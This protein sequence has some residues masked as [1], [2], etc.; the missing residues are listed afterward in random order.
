[1]KELTKKER[2]A[3]DLEAEKSLLEDIVFNVLDK[4]TWDDKKKIDTLLLYDATLNLNLDITNKT[5]DKKRVLRK[6][7]II[8]RAI[9]QIDKALGD[10]F[11]IHQDDV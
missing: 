3:L 11:L 10:T 8:Y 1:M 2:Q 7:K 6:S 5:K 4:K 9:K